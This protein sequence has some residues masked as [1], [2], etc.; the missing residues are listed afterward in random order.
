MICN[1]NFFEMRV[2]EYQTDE[3]ICSEIRV[4][5]KNTAK[6][7]T[8]VRGEREAVEPHKTLRLLR[9]QGERKN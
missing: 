7:I 3:K 4:S 6:N 9:A 8:T 1:S 2:I 5:S